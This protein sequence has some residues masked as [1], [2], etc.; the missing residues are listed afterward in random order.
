LLKLVILL[1]ADNGA[2]GEAGGADYCCVEARVKYGKV[3]AS[4]QQQ[5]LLSCFFKD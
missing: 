1:S 4:K 2:G 5:F 3:Q